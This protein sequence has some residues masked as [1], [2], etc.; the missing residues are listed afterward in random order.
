MEVKSNL[1]NRVI[2]KVNK[3]SVEQIQQVEKFIDS[4]KEKESNTQLIFASSKLA[5]SVFERVWDN[6]EDAE[7]DK[8]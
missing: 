3:L 8:L 6:P 4:L 2:A 7:Y 1:E 5:Q